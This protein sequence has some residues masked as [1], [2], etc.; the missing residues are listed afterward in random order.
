MSLSFIDERHLNG[1]STGPM[2]FVLTVGGDA[3]TL[4]SLPATTAERA[5][6]E[7]ADWWR[8]QRLA[9]RLLSGAR[10]MPPYSATTL[11]FPGGRRVI[12]DGPFT[13]E[14]EAIGAFGIIDVAH[15]D[16]AMAVACAWPL[17]GYVEIRPLMSPTSRI[18]G[19]RPTGREEPLNR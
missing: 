18:F 7:V 14:I 9:G 11:R 16:E 2:L 12:T 6:G 10:L 13:P 15:L 17:G 3:V 1:A 19:Y 8:A 4:E 5:L